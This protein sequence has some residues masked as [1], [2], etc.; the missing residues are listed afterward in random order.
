M[1]R[2]FWRIRTE[3]RS[4][5]ALKGMTWRPAD[6]IHFERFEFSV[7]MISL[8]HESAYAA[9]MFRVATSWLAEWF[10]ALNLV[11][12]L[13]PPAR[14]FLPSIAGVGSRVI[15]SRTEDCLWVPETFGYPAV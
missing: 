1:D 14:E 5:S 15:A 6:G 10:R 13:S 4:R 7:G 12:V 8:P 3:E 11:P 2:G 9:M